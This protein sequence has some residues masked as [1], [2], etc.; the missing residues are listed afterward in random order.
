MTAL[1]LRRKPSSL[2]L[3]AFTILLTSSACAL[4]LPLPSQPTKPE[5]AFNGGVLNPA[6][7]LAPFELQQ[8][9]GARFRSSTTAGRLSLVFFGYTFCPDVCPLTLAHVA[10]VRRELGA[11]ARLVDVYFITVDPERDTP[12]R[13]S[14]YL[15]KFDPAIVGLTGTPE[16]LE[17]VRKVFGVLAK[18]RDVPESAAGY[19]VDHTAALYLI[20]AESRLRIV[21]PYGV[22]PQEIVA[23]L[24]QL[25]P[26]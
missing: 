19:F 20:D 23:D 4:P 11:S 5:P 7:T 24:R 3:L 1:Q 21:Y 18:R 14:E 12:S 15:S 13:L 8:A 22:T 25:L 9:D 2:A 17:Q 6:L 26:R 10:Q 16:E